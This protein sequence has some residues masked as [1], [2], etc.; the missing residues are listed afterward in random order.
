[1]MPTLL[2]FV[3]LLFLKVYFFYFFCCVPPYFFFLACCGGE[4]ERILLRGR[5][6]KSKRR[7]NADLPAA[8]PNEPR[9]KHRSRLLFRAAAADSEDDDRI[10]CAWHYVSPVLVITAY[11]Y[12]VVRH[13]MRFG[14][15][16]FTD[17][18][19]V[20]VK[21]IRCGPRGSLRIG[22]VGGWATGGGKQTHRKSAMRF[23]RRMMREHMREH[24]LISFFL[25]QLLVQRK[26]SFIHWNAG[27]PRARTRSP[28]FAPH[29]S[30][31]VRDYLRK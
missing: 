6:Q 25:R 17:Y 19:S 11:C 16:Y 15:E 20:V 28:D 22:R 23:D 7:L 2:P 3:P 31:F 24:I 13:A 14:E 30:T 4:Q 21:V 8:A 9:T 29:I 5:R 12:R 27:G 18:Y 26:N 10:D 1:M